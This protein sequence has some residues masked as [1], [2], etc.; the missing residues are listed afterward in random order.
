[1]IASFTKWDNSLSGTLGAGP[2]GVPLSEVLLYTVSRLKK[3]KYRVNE[4]VSILLHY[5]N[6]NCLTKFI[7]W[8]RR[9]ACHSDQLTRQMLQCVSIRFNGIVKGFAPLRLYLRPSIAYL[10]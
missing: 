1:M 7:V 5:S 4:N 9:F 6:S 3:Y 2:T 10:A 8:L